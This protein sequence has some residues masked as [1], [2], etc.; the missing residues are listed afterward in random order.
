[1]CHEPQQGISC[2]QIH[3]VLHNTACIITLKVNLVLL[4]LMKD[5]VMNAIIKLDNSN[6]SQLEF[7]DVRW[8]SKHFAYSYL[9]CSEAS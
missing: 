1:M 8:E 3:A 7:R 9:N 4:F 2:S 6:A 5:Y